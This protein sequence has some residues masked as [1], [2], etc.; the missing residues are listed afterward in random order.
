MFNIARAALLSVGVPEGDLPRKHTGVIAAFA[1]HAVQSGHI[2]PDLA[3]ALGRTESLRLRADYTGTE[4]DVQTAADT[5]ARAEAFV[6]TV[7]RVFALHESSR[8]TGSENDNPGHGDKVSEPGNAV[9]RMQENYPH[10][11][12]LSLEEE[13]RQARENWLRLRR[14]KLEDARDIDHKRDIG[15]HAKEELSH[16]PDNDLD[17]E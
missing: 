1:Q 3:A 2:D 7:A 5:V 9:G 4:I 14:Q 10:P 8:T 12:P 6:G 13:R 15:R 16:A 17:D 11:Q